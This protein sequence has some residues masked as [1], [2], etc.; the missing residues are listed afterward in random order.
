MITI[1]Q[2]FDKRKYSQQRRDKIIQ[3]LTDNWINWINDTKSKRIHEEMMKMLGTTKRLEKVEAMFAR[4]FAE[5]DRVLNNWRL[6]SE[7]GWDKTR[8]GESKI[9]KDIC[10]FCNGKLIVLRPKANLCKTCVKVFHRN[11]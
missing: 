5:F 9:D 2:Y 7:S 6:K 10:P 3:L 1:F 4:E 8:E 11:G